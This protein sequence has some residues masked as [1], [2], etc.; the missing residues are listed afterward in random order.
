[1]KRFIKRKFSGLSL[2]SKQT[3]VIVGTSVTCILFACSTFFFNDMFFNKQNFERETAAL[4]ELVRINSIAPLYFDDPDAGNEVLASLKACDDIV[5][6]AALYRPE[7]G[8]FATYVR[9]AE[10]TGAAGFSF[11]EKPWQQGSRVAGSLNSR[12]YEVRFKQKLIGYLYLKNDTTRYK[13][14]LNW[15]AA[16]AVGISIVSALIAVFMSQYLKRPVLGPVFHLV[17]TAREISTEKDFSIRARTFYDDEIGDLILG[18]NE[19]IEK[20]Q[21]RDHELEQY[22]RTLEKKVA[23]RTRQLEAEKWRAEQASSAKSDFLANMSHELRT[24]LNGIIG[25]TQ[26]FLKFSGNLTEEEKERIQVIHQC[27]EHLLEMINDILDL[28]KVEAGKLEIVQR[29]FH[30]PRFI[31][32]GVA[33]AQSRAGEKGLAISIN[34]DEDLPVYVSG[35]DHRIRQV[36]LNLLS[37]AVKFTRAG[38]ITVSVGRTPSGHVRFRVADTGIGIPEDFLDGIFDAFTQIGDV[39]H[40]AEGTGL[41]LA[42]CKKLVT[43]MGG[44]IYVQSRLGRGSNFWFDLPLASCSGGMPDEEPAW[45]FNQITG[46]RREGTDRPV[47]VLVVDDIPDNRSVLADVLTSTGFEVDEAGDGLEAVAAC[48]ESA[49]DLV[50]MDVIMPVMD[51]IEAT[52]KIL[53]NINEDR[54][55]PGGFQPPVVLAISASI[56]DVMRKTAKTSGCRAILSKPLQMETLFEAIGNALELEWEIERTETEI[57]SDTVQPPPVE[58]MEELRTLAENGDIA[59][60]QEW[61]AGHLDTHPEFAGFIGKIDALARRFRI[62]DIKALVDDAPVG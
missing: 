60:V 53:G 39:H 5:I 15:Y 37:N 62:N 47:R 6:A 8:L 31:R 18:F 26:L 2:H 17:K 40:K 44:D 27:G 30:L 3:L 12:V 9:T 35:D 19:M 43:L 61:C 16:L 38:N 25:Y 24:P 23:E 21:R 10:Q 49:Y 55:R 54:N 45:D 28:T 52:G 51:G 20:I 56:S 29:T 57:E 4:M 33:I 50:L 22:R 48:S 36:L 59:G 42:I 14:L 58:F 11:P 34:C 13:R 41:G 7:G 32:S 46:Y 1:M